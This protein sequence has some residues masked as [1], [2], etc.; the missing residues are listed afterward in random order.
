MWALATVVVMQ[1]TAS[2]TLQDIP[3]IM[4]RGIENYRRSLIPSSGMALAVL[5][6]FGAA[7]LTAQRFVDSNDLL[8]AFMIDLSG[9]VAA[10][11]LALP[12]FRLALNIERGSASTEVAP[13]NLA[14]GA[15]V[16]GALFF[17]G[18]FLLGIRYMLGIPSVFVLIWYG[19]FGFAVADGTTPGLNALGA[20]V[21]LGQGR[22]WTIAVLAFVLAF[23]NFLALLPIGTGINALTAVGALLLLIITTNI[24]MGAGAHLYDRLLQSEQL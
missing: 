23:L 19:V 10:T 18:G 4:S 2:P 7:R 3:E 24:S 14:W 13:A 6:L 1:R 12:W 20:S 9:L 16:V 17:W 22:R 21:R 15:M 5:V 8:I 11:I